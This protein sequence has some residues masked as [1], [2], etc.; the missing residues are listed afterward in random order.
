L[1]LISIF[2]PRIGAGYTQNG[3]DHHLRQRH[4]FEMEKR[5]PLPECL[6]FV[7]ALNAEPQPRTQRAEA[8]LKQLNRC[9][10]IEKANVLH[11]IGSTEQ[12]RPRRNFSR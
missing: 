2:A 9:I 6:R 10:R 4:V 1:R 5:E 11:A 12:L 3:F 8:G 7:L